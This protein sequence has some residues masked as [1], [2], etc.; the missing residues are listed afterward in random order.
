MLQISLSSHLPDNDND[1]DFQA[2]QCCCRMHS[3]LSAPHF[4]KILLTWKGRNTSRWEMYLCAESLSV[5]FT[6]QHGGWSLYILSRWRKNPS[7]WEMMNSTF[8]ISQSE[9]FTEL[10]T[11]LKEFWIWL[12]RPPQWQIYFAIH[13]VHLFFFFSSVVAMYCWH[14]HRSLQCS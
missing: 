12:L 11:I 3:D 10:L 14:I 6:W 5:V 13:K 2:F 4:R 1:K 9:G 8:I 7:L